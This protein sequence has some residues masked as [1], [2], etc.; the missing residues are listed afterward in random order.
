MRQPERF[1]VPLAGRVVSNASFVI[2]IISWFSSGFIGSYAGDF[3]GP[4]LL[5]L[6][7]RQTARGPRLFRVLGPASAACL[8]FIGCTAFEVAQGLRWVTGWFDPLDIACY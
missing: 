6:A 1:A 2:S 3:F 8:E 4:I 5:Y 7:I